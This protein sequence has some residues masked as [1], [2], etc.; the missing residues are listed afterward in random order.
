M[1]SGHGFIS[2][3][4]GVGEGRLRGVVYEQMRVRLGDRTVTV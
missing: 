1:P 3:C 4:V 2:K